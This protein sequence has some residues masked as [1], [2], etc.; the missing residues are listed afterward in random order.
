MQKASLKRPRIKV[1]PKTNHGNVE[2]EKHHIQD[3]EYAS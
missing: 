3:E 1:E 2:E